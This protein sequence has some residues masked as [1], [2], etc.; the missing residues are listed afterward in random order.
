MKTLDDNF[1]DWESHV[2]GYGYGS[3]EPHVIPS[4]AIFLSL[5]NEDGSYDYRH[6]ESS[7]HPPIVWML[8]NA[9]ARADILEYGSSP[10]FGWLTKEGKAL[11]SFIESKSI[12]E[13]I[14]LSC[15]DSEYTH[16]YS[17]A[18]NCGPHGYEKERVCPNPFWKQTPSADSVKTT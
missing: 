18:C 7:M 6:L 16:C 2:F 11:K 13:L 17:N 1:S 10:R 14:G 3:G 12:D 5:F 15:R 9:L 4:L 8:I